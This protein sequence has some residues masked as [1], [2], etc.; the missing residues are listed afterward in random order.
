MLKTF[1]SITVDDSGK[2]ITPNKNRVIFAGGEFTIHDGSKK[3]L[4]PLKIANTKDGKY[5]E[6][7]QGKYPV[8]L[9]TF[10]DISSENIGEIE[11][12]LKL[13]V[14]QIFLNFHI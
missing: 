9:I 8:I 4:K 12:A 5:I 3:S 11:N 13:K 14:R 6:L 10:K 2:I 1:A 7:Y